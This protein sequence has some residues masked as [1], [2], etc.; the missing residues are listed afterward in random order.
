M[1]SWVWV[2]HVLTRA[3]GRRHLSDRDTSTWPLPISSGIFLF[4][5]LKLIAD[6]FF[7]LLL[8][9][10][11]RN[12]SRYVVGSP[13]SFPVLPVAVDCGFVTVSRW[14]ILLESQANQTITIVASLSR[15][16][17]SP[18]TTCL[19]RPRLSLTTSST[20]PSRPVLTGETLPSP[21]VSYILYS[22]LRFCF[23][24]VLKGDLYAIAC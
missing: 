16:M 22:F 24:R 23:L 17:S 21:R 6:L 8:Q 11:E 12:G 18:T 2:D 3:D 20:R 15:N 1:P 13:F 10:K 4:F 14:V 9:L 7:L 19:T 5:S